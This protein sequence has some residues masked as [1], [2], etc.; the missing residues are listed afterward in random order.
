MTNENAIEILDR[1]GKSKG[2]TL[3][4]HCEA[5]E[6]FRAALREVEQARAAVEAWE[7][8]KE[9]MAGHIVE[10]DWSG[11]EDHPY[12]VIVDG[13]MADE[14][15]FYGPTPQAAILAAKGE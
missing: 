8:V 10:F 11:E 2:Y 14:K 9:V 4:E 12:V 13:Q 6:M 15:R 1:W 5:L 7:A 3:P